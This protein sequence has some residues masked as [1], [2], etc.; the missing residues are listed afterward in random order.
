MLAALAAG[1]RVDAHHLVRGAALFIQIPMLFGV[2]WHLCGD[3]GQ[4]LMDA[5]KSDLMGNEREA[6]ALA[7]AAAW[8]QQHPEQ[9]RPSNWSP[10]PACMPA[11]LNTIG[12][13]WIC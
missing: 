13:R 3:I 9:T 2:V 8:Y 1:R 12:W 6:T 5:A 4:A 7:L 10:R 11:G